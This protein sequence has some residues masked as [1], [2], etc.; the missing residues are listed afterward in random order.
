M[1]TT[2]T[3]VSPETCE[4][5]GAEKTSDELQECDKCV[6][7]FCDTE[8]SSCGIY[9]NS[10]YL[11]LCPDCWTGDTNHDYESRSCYY[12]F[13]EATPQVSDDAPANAVAKHSPQSQQPQ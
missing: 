5:C 13:V 7:R 8:D 9:C 4:V 11:L 6:V 10:C 12:C 1:T 3:D 2:I